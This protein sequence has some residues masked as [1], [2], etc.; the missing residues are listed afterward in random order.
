MHE[1]RLRTRWNDFDALGH[2]TH[3]AYPMF[4]DEARDAFFA[5]TVGAFEE[6]PVVIVHLSV[7]HH[8][9]IRRPAPEIVVRTRV[10]SV[11]R[12]SVTFEQELSAGDGVAAVAKAVVVAWDAE[13]RAARALTD[14]ERATLL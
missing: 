5:E 9:E 12:T 10:T 13:A 7:D 8:G 1:T 14:D 3:I 2:L 6:F 11:G 4:F